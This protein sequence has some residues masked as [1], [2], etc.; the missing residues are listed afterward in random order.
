MRAMAG[1][2][3][4]TMHATRTLRLGALALGL[5]VLASGAAMAA[6][7]HFKG[8][9]SFTDGGLFLTESGA[10]SGVGNGDL[11]I[12]L[13]AHAIPTATCTNPSGGNQ[14]AGQ[15][16]AHLTVS[17]GTVVPGADGRSKNGVTYFTVSTNAPSRNVAGAPDCPNARWTE[18]LSDLAFTDAT[19]TFSQGGV[20]VLTQTCTFSPATSDGNV[21]ARQVT[22]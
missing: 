22:C 13:T 2:P 7:V 3:Q 20:V 8:T 18:T 1:P 11:T 21:P 16:G 14:P 10:V 9:P 17:G 6:N 19:I 12:T 5:L 4:P 15:N